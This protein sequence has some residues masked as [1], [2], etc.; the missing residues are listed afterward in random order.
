MSQG[1]LRW[2]SFSPYH[3]DPDGFGMTNVR[4]MAAFSYLYP[5]PR[6]KLMKIA[7][8]FDF[9][10]VSGRTDNAYAREAIELTRA[11]MAAGDG[12]G[13]LEMRREPGGR[14]CLLDTR[15]ERAQAPRRAVLEGWKA[16]VYLACDRAQTMSRLTQLPQVRREGVGAEELRAFLD[17]CVDYQLMVRN[18]GSWLGVAVHTPARE[19][20][21]DSVQVSV[22]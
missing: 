20:V 11:W 17:R 8:Y 15:G 2:S 7:Y 14:V 12:R 10:Y 13:M 6:E 4:P 9:D 18:E 3:A 1:R 19:R 22:G 16:A 5:F 21:E